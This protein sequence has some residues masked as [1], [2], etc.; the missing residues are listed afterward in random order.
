[1]EFVDMGVFAVDCGSRMERVAGPMVALLF[2]FARRGGA[3]TGRRP[4]WGVLASFI[5]LKIVP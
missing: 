3:G 2:V 4:S 1:M 5:A